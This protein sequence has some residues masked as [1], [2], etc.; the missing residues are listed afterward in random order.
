[1]VDSFTNCNQVSFTALTGQLIAIEVKAC[2]LHHL[3]NLAGN[4]TGQLIAR[5]PKVRQLSQLPNLGGNGTCQSVARKLELDD[6]QTIGT[7]RHAVQT[8]QQRRGGSA[9]SSRLAPRATVARIVH[10]LK[11]LA[12]REVERNDHKCGAVRDSLLGDQRAAAVAVASIVLQLHTAMTEQD[13]EITVRRRRRGGLGPD[14]RFQRRNGCRFCVDGKP[15][16]H[17][18]ARA[19][20][21]DA[22]VQQRRRRRRLRLASSSSSSSARQATVGQQKLRVR[23][24][25]DQQSADHLHHQ[26]CV[27]GVVVD[28]GA[29]LLLLLLL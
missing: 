24:V 15:S 9:P 14:S 23:Q 2:Q 27:V 16:N 13:A 11:D 17:Q 19:G 12:L 22:D 29:A 25:A 4:G 20:R 18:V 7:G 3:P 26:R 28:V 5:E 8:R 10:P 1:M 6:V 21:F